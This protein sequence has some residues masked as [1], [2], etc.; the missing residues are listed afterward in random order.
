MH[1]WSSQHDLESLLTLM[2]QGDITALTQIHQEA[3]QL[4]QQLEQQLEQ[5]QDALEVRGVTRQELHIERTL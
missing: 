4:V 5:V 3:T 1:E 2:E